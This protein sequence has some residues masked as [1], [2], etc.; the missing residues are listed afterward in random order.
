MW[1][2]RRYQVPSRYRL[3]ALS[4]LDL[5]TLYL[6]R[7]DLSSLRTKLLAA[8][9]W[10]ALVGT[11]R[12][13]LDLV[14]VAVWIA[15]LWVGLGLLITVL[16]TRAGWVGHL[17]TRLAKRTLPA[18]MRRGLAGALGLSL[19]LAPVGAG[20]TGS[21][22]TTGTSGRAAASATAAFAGP[23]V[24]WPNSAL[25]PAQSHPPMSSVPWPQTPSPVSAPASP[26]ET[27]AGDDVIVA[28]GDCLWVIAA[29]RLQAP[30]TDPQIAAA[31]PA[32]FEVN[33]DVIGADPAMLRPGQHLHAP[34]P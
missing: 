20:A 24:A 16:A 28:A 21:A 14:G 27:A 2:E 9:E 1:I 34:K 4:A 5:L 6:G 12:A 11:D 17:G 29:R 8:H 26:R 30:A 31:W 18:M 33:G 10:V 32:W 19:V 3:Y 25:P 13:L 15:A 7:P 22:S 23:D